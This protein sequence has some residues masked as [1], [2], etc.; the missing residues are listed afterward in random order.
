MRIAVAMVKVSLHSSDNPKAVLYF[1]SSNRSS[2]ILRFP[3]SP[4]KQYLHLT[5]TRLLG[6]TNGT[7]SAITVTAQVTITDRGIQIECCRWRKY[8]VIRK[9]PLFNQVVGIILQK[10]TSVSVSGRKSTSSKRFLCYP[11]L[12]TILLGRHSFQTCEKPYRSNVSRRRGPQ[13]RKCLP[14]SDCPVINDRCGEGLIHC[15]SA[16]PRLVVLSGIRKQGE[17]VRGSK[18]LS[19]V[20]LQRLSFSSCPDF[21]N[22]GCNL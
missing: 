11:I 5:F 13:L 12:H 17:A 21:P 9:A 2:Q 3:G 18:T 15:E 16:T 4:T 6:G 1:G 14:P 19:G 7:W 8:K 10:K 22:T 20:F